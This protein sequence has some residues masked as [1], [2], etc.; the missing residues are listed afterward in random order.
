MC[1]F[2]GEIKPELNLKPGLANS[3]DIEVAR[4]YC[5][6]RRRYLVAVTFGHVVY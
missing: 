1:L 6:C 2:H 3:T 5:Q 4:V